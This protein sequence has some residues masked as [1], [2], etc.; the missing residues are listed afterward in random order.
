LVEFAQVVGDVL[1]RARIARGFSFRGV[2]DRTAGKFKPSALGGYERGERS[3]SLT[4]FCDLAEVY[5]VPA[6]R[7]LA[8]VL[9]RMPGEGPRVLVVDLTKI[10]LV[11]ETERTA[12]EEFVEDVRARRGAYGS[13]VV[14]LRSGDLEVIASTSGLDAGTLLERL[15][16][17]LEEPTGR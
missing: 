17:A 2:R 4:R 16:P 15:R 8:E 3:V 9:E 1:R 13:N 12:L 6:D 5:G 7:L 11:S 14:T 10:S